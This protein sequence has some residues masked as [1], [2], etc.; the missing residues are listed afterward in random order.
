MPFRASEDVTYIAPFFGLGWLI[1]DRNKMNKEAEGK[2][3][4]M[5]FGAVPL[6]IIEA[7]CLYKFTRY[8]IEDPINFINELQKGISLVGKY[9]PYLT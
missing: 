6:N 7:V 2:F 9:A 1:K 3:A 4:A 8:V 5:M